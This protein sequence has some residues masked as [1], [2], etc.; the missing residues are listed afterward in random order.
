M[1]IQDIVKKAEFHASIEKV[2]ETVTTAE[3]IASWF[4]P[5]DFKRELHHTF[6]LKTPY[7][8]TPCKVL[9]LEPPRRLTFSWGEDGWIVTFELE[10][11]G[12]GKTA[13]TLTHS[14]WNEM[15]DVV[16]AS[17]QHPAVIRDRMN[18]GWDNIVGV[19][20][21]EAVES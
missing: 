10:D 19:K 9:E 3:G 1:S 12:V 7:G 5:N 15:G 6:T 11:L 18:G 4:M 13:F 17:G 21:R 8:D 16:P 14:G 20:L 2:W